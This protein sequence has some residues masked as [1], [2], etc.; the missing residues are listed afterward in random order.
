MIRIR[1]I[2]L[3]ALLALGR[4]AF[5]A[6]EPATGAPQVFLDKPPKIVEYQLKRLNN[7]QLL[8]VERKTDSPKYKPV[9]SAILTRKGIEKKHRQE[10]L[11]ALVKLNSTD[12]I[13]ELLSAIGKV[14]AEDK[15]TQYE[16]AGMLVAQKPSD[17]AKQRETIETLA[18]D[19]ESPASKQAAYAAL[20]AADGAPE[21][22]W[23]LAKANDGL[24]LLVQ[25]LPMM[26]DAK[27]RSTLFTPVKG[28]LAE[29]PDEL[30]LAAVDGLSYTGN[31]AE[32]F[33]LLAGYVSGDDAKL[34][35]AA[36]R[37][38]K[39][40]PAAKWPKDQVKPLGDAVVK[41]IA[42]TPG[43]ERATPSIVQAVS[44]G[45]E[46]ASAL[47]PDQGLPLKKQLRELGIRSIVLRT[48]REQMLYDLHYFVVQ[49]GKPVQ[50]LL[51]NADVMPH[52]VVVIAPGALQEIGTVS[53][54]M[55]APADPNEKAYVP[56]DPRVL[57]ATHMTQ[58][59]ESATLSFTAPDKPG[60]YPFVCTFPGHWVRMYGVML[61]VPDLDAWEKDPKPPT[62]PMT[63]KPY[64][65]QKNDAKDL[66]GEGHEH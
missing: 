54:A 20:V 26:T 23:E 35:D 30:K 42:K 8:A 2:A 60:E 32:A 62:D 39:R 59:D 13:T 46:L 16:L 57:H 48:I 51:D 12:P 53:N 17:L 15:Q 64:P 33:K 58:P 19:A 63:K 3:V 18:K 28:L 5:A 34:R 4:T 66:A 41:W 37:S 38:L 25:S 45:E 1:H 24:I 65:S 56:A 49:Q 22:A 10:S 21:K 11:A 52:N 44:F 27:V 50:I 7:P 29:G 31:E 47:P 9:Y 61:V 6:D 55:P 14:D 43:E 40:I 36:V